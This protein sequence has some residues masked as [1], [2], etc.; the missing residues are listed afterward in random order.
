MRCRKGLQPFPVVVSE[1]CSNAASKGCILAGWQD[2]R[3][4]ADLRVS[5]STLPAALSAVHA[6]SEKQYNNPALLR[7]PARTVPLRTVRAALVFTVGQKPASNMKQAK[8]RVRTKNKISPMRPPSHGFCHCRSRRPC[9]ARG[10]RRFRQEQWR[11][12]ISR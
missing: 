9:A 8:Q 1:K 12:Q 10:N 5:I 6:L 11:E 2:L 4:P 3:N 7:A